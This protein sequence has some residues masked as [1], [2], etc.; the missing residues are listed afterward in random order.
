MSLDILFIHPNASKKIYQGLSND[1]SAIEPPIWAGMLANH[2]RNK[3]FNVQILDCEVEK[4]DYLTS[5]KEIIKIKPRIACFVVY[6]QQPSASS[7]NMEGAIATS[8]ELKLSDPEIKILFVGGHVS[9]LPNETLTNEK[10]IDFIA[11]NEGVYA[12]SNLLKVENLNDEK[13]LNKVKGI[14]FRNKDNQIVI[15]ESEIIVPKKL[16]DI[17][18][19]GIAW[20]LLPS[21]KKYRTAGWHSWSNNSDKQPFAALYTSLG[22]PYTCSFCMINIINRTDSSE[23]ISSQDSNIF[24]WW[25]PEF[26]IR[27]FDYFAKQG[28][29]NIKIADELFVLNPNHFMK[30]CDMIIERKYNFNI[31]AYSRIDTCKPEYLEKLKK[32]GVNWLGLGIENPSSVIRKEVHKDAFK[33]VKIIDIINSIR[34]A[35]INV[36]ANYIFGLPEETKESLEFTYNFA[37]ET[38]TEMVNFYSAMAYPGSP[39]YLESKKKNIILPKTYSGYSQHSYDT[40]NLP[41]ANLSASEILAFRDK[42]WNKYHTNSKYLKLL[43]SKFGM[44]AINNLK[45]TTKIKLKRKLLGD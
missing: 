18:L 4:L 20:D 19:P 40:Q 34:N 38:N 26:I 11:L 9:A 2:C 17:D 23:N 33:N 6:G 45:A 32:A 41:S 37:E 24:R 27:Q 35:G 30:I 25:S 44:N 1:H 3:N 14:G 8:E 16:L 7:Q 42:A 29:K 22:C 39:L 28:V 21:L 36:A 5:V 12:I 43:E 15:N 13:Y 10:S 31:W